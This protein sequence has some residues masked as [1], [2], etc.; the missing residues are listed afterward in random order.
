MR[1]FYIILGVVVLFSFI[2]CAQKNSD[3]AYYERAN[4]VSK[5]AL[6]ELEKE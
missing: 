1:T 4:K 5:E 3:N 2:G 6:F